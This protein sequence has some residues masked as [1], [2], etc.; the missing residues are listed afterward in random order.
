[1][2]L[3]LVMFTETGERRDFPLQ[4]S[5][6]IVGRDS[7][8]DLQI[9]LAEVS[10]RHCEISIKKDKVSVRDLGSSNG[11]Y[12][13][14]KRIQQATLSAGNT[15]TV[16]PVVFTVVLNGKPADVKPVRTILEGKKAP[17]AEK[18]AAPKD[19][20]GSL[21]LADSGALELDDD[22]SKD[23]SSLAALEELSKQRKGKP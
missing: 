17:A 22:D 3:V 23:S 10:R 21:D 7:D 15:L 12:I 16:G 4:A 2:D 13:N 9:P 20:T 19:E 6:A 14:N 18:K 1:M 5:K 8:A 11:T